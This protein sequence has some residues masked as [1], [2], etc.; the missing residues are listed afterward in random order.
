MNEIIKQKLELL[1][2]KPGSYQ[3]FDKEG[4]IIYVGKAKNLKNR[5]KSYF[6]G[7]HNA[8]TT[9]LV[10]EIN[11]LEYIITSTE[12]EALVLEIN[13]I[14]KHMPKYN[15]SLTDD[16]MYPYI[17]LTNET[18]PRIL[19]T[20]DI[21]K[22]K[23]KVYGPYPNAYAAKEVVDLLNRMYPLR[24]CRK[25]PKKECLYYHMG[26][27]LAPC[28]NKV[29][30]SIYD[31]IKN[32]INSILKGN[33]HDEIKKFK[34][35]MNEASD[36][37]D[38]EKAIEYRNIIN[39]LEQVSQRQKMEEHISDT[40]VF[41]YF[42]NDD[43][44]S[45]QVFHIREGKMIE[46]NG[47]LFENDGNI[48]EKYQEFVY[49]FYLVENNPFPKQ[50]FLRD[51]N[52]EELQSFNDILDAKVIVPKMGRN[53]EL[54]K[55]VCD[56]AKNKID[57]L[58]RKKELEYQR[59]EKTFKDLSN[60]LGF[61]VHKV[62]AFD[63]SNIQGASAVSA[64]VVYIDGK[65]AKNL[66]RKFKIKTVVGANDVATMYEVVTRRYKDIGNK[67][68]LIIMDGGKLQVD[69]CKKALKDINQ[70]IEV[71]GLVKDDNHKTR[72]LF[73][74]DKEIEIEKGSYLFHMMEAIQEEVHRFAISFFRS[75]HNKSL[76]TSKLDE[77]K[78][79]GKV[80]KNQILKLLSSNNFK[81]D[82][83]KLKLNDYQKEEILKA[84]KII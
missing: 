38:F 9:K 57:N 29:D 44:L 8:K 43:Y 67:P 84:Y 54:V 4:T 83:D 81:E 30:K 2:D 51:I 64:M 58:I 36:N 74:N 59:T 45:I 34:V 66:Y 14:K 80:K 1:P 10:S 33:V 26:Q 52:E 41:G 24:K 16:K 6:V 53:L 69:S 7:S 62:E 18:H 79:I 65:K 75:T 13:L 28:I 72:A 5:V 47:Y 56:N 35:L 78:G 23:G 21:K 39:S 49:N 27:C 40:D 60:L 32:K 19:Y 37:L 31:D 25:L 42:A 11:D 48:V 50:I 20:R 3:Y 73:Y 46:R 61:E 55:L 15:I 76:F 77:I 17:V 68:D 63:N 71:L 82:L 22:Q 70:D 12:E